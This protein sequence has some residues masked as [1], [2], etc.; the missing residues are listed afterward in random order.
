MHFC[1]NYDDDSCAITIQWTGMSI[2]SDWSGRDVCFNAMDKRPRTQNEEQRHLAV[3]A[4]TAMWSIC[5][6][7]VSEPVRR[8]YIFLNVIC[9]KNVFWSTYSPLIS[10]G[11]GSAAHSVQW[12]VFN[13]IERSERKE[14]NNIMKMSTHQSIF[15]FIT[16]SIWNNR[17]WVANF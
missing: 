10:S 14:K 4:A 15:H 2:E 8:E 7:G 9:G 12:K 1:D 5:L 17:R 3:N 16:Y 6:Y 11:I 13:E